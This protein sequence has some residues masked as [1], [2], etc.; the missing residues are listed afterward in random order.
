M[1]VTTALVVISKYLACAI[2]LYCSGPSTSMAGGGGGG[3]RPE[4]R[5]PSSGDRPRCRRRSLSSSSYLLL[6]LQ[7]VSFVF[8]A[9]LSNSFA[10]LLSARSYYLATTT[11][12]PWPKAVCQLQLD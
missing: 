3:M 8:H 11:S 4:P 2:T 5:P 12:G 1:S 10:C 9:K 6:L 7:C